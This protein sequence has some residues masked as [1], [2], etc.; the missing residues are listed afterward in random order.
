MGTT[1]AVGAPV[2]ALLYQHRPGPVLRAT[3]GFLY[4]VSSLVMLGLL[5]LAG[6]FGVHELSL[7]LALMPGVVIGYLTAQQAA[8]YLDRGHT[9]KAVL[10]LSALSAVALI[11]R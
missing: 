5:H 3:L 4:V 6:R 1:A 2:L 9:R 8:R 7:G 10:L 11:V